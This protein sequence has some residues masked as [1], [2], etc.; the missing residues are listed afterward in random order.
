MQWA[1]DRDGSGPVAIENL[2]SDMPAPD[3]VWN[4]ASQ[5]S[6]EIVYADGIRAFVSD[7]FENGVRFIGEGGREIFVYRGKLVMKP[8]GLIR[9]KIRPE[10]IHLYV[11]G[12]HE[13]NFIECIYSGK[14]TIA[15]CEVGHRSITIAHLA[16]AGLRLGLKRIQWDPKAEKYIGPG[17]SDAERLML[18]PMRGDWSL[19]PKV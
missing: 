8:D 2:Q 9:E 4:I 15:P 14:P 5:Y 18:A 7:R 17:A 16:N 10:E 12:Q 3:K 1:L 11:S 6:F 13:K 19:D